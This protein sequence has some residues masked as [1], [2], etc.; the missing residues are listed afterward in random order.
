MIA[1]ESIVTTAAAVVQLL[2]SQ[3][4]C[5]VRTEQKNLGKTERAA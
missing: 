2:A 1:I 5:A 4:R 3:N